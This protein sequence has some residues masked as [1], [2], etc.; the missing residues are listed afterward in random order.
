MPFFPV[1]PLAWTDASPPTSRTAR[2][3]K[4]MMAESIHT[5][6]GS[7]RDV[8][9]RWGNGIFISIVGNGP[10]E[11]GYREAMTLDSRSSKDPEVRREVRSCFAGMPG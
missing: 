9:S 3:E 8:K 5:G 11:C 2:R 6:L 7:P 10:I 1:S 4:I